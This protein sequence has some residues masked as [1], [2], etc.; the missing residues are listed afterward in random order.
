M[1]KA[2]FLYLEPKSKT[3][4]FAQCANC[5]MFIADHKVC[6]LHGKNVKIEPTMSCGLYVPGGPAVE[7]ELEHVEAN[8]SPKESGL[9][10][11]KVRCEHCEYYKK[12][13]SECLLFEILGVQDTKVIADGCCNAW[14]S[15]AIDEKKEDTK[16]Q[17]L[18][19]FIK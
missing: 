4:N 13:E 3:H 14:H 17:T 12:N 18:K 19:R 1:T 6:S 16:R 2:T 7:S 10:N 11:A 15:D 5:K 9:I 8:V